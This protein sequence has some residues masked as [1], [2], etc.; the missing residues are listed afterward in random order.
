MRVEASD[1]D[2]LITFEVRTATTEGTYG[3]KSYSWSANGEE[4]A[5]VMD[6]LPSR[7]EQ[8]ADGINLQRR[9]VRIRTRYR[10]DITSD[11]RI[12]YE[13]RIV[14]IIAGPVEIGRCDGIEMVCEDYSTEG[15]QP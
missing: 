13:G 1:L 7:G 12:S 11:M 15:E 10:D 8:V 3:T 2:T 4:W 9:P 5:Q 6:M 14:Q